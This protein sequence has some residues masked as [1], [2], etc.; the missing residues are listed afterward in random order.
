MGTKISMRHSI[1]RWNCK[2]VEGNCDYDLRKQVNKN[3]WITVL[4]SGEA[5]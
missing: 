1:R 4:N 2:G 3:K 5:V